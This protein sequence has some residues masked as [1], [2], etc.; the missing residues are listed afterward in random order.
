MSNHPIASS[1]LSENCFSA[2][3]SLQNGC[4]LGSC[5]HGPKY[6]MQKSYLKSLHA[7]TYGS[8]IDKEALDR[9]RGL[10]AQALQDSLMDVDRISLEKDGI[11]Y[12]ALTVRQAEET[13]DWCLFVQDREAPMELH[14]EDL[15]LRCQEQGLNLLIVNGPNLG[16]S[17]G[18]VKK[19][20]FGQATEAA[21]QYLEQEVRA[22]KVALLADGFGAA[23]LCAAVSSHFFATRGPIYLGAR[24]NAAASLD[25]H[26]PGCKR[27]TARRL[28]LKQD[29]TQLS[30]IFQERLFHEIIAEPCRLSETNGYMLAPEVRD[31]VGKS[32][33]E[34]EDRL[35]FHVLEDSQVNQHFVGTTNMSPDWAR[36][37][38]Y[39]KGKALQHIMI[40]HHNRNRLA[41]PDSLWIRS[42][43][44]QM[45]YDWL[46]RISV[47]EL[48]A[49]RTLW[50]GLS[51]SFTRYYYYASL[52]ENATCPD[53][54]P[55]IKALLFSQLVDREWVEGE[56]FGDFMFRL[57]AQC[58]WK[59]FG[60]Q[61][62][63][64]LRQI[65]FDYDFSRKLY[66]IIG[67]IL[68]TEVDAI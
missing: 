52:P 13:Q 27:W 4:C 20:T 51:E 66:S 8:H 33:L 30:R 48:G 22:K 61:D 14:L 53:F 59:G 24:V 32:P 64:T 62:E 43:L 6:Y 5:P 40:H 45:A 15:S 63:D 7:Q 1:A 34:S 60:E 2:D 68:A 9:L 11:H 16:R 31:L 39:W 35:A 10:V 37:S 12:D 65:A 17:E 38:G 41:T 50:E 18:S 25:R 21:M 67:G 19:K 26:F 55:T 56:N 36:Q 49:N 3:P 57:K 28:G 58:I 47:D 54:L 42:D 46:S 29:Q 23:K 44:P